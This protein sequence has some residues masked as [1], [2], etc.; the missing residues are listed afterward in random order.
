MVNKKSPNL[1][2]R[3]QTCAWWYTE[4]DQIVTC[5]C[6]NHWVTV[7]EIC[8]HIVRLEHGAWYDFGT[9]HGLLWNE[10]ADKMT[11]IMEATWN[12]YSR[13]GLACV[14]IFSL[15]AQLKI[16]IQNTPNLSG[17]CQIVDAPLRCVSV[18]HL[19]T[20]KSFACMRYIFE[21][22]QPSRVINFWFEF[23]STQ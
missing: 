14:S 13:F 10:T 20:T 23:Y 2:T 18:L 1:R 12:E 21:E 15:H 7:N 8:A 17:D 19:W 4:T 16:R 9:F 11:T 5:Y 6:T 3:R 22:C